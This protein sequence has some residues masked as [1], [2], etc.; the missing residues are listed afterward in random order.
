MG[1]EALDGAFQLLH[2][3]KMFPKLAKQSK[4]QENY[5]NTQRRK[6]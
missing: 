6:I 1:P 2:T 5:N 3:G 4:N